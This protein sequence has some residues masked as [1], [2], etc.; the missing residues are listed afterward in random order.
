M[1]TGGR[2]SWVSMFPVFISPV[3]LPVPLYPVLIFPVHISP[4]L[5]SPVPISPVL[6]SQVPKSPVPI[7]GD[8][9]SSINFLIQAHVHSFRN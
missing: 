1:N 3:T 9:I 5:M 8:H 6:M 4:V 2:L 7:S